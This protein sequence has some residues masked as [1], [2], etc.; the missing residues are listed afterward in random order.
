MTSEINRQRNTF[1]AATGG[2]LNPDRNLTL[3]IECLRGLRIAMNGC[4]ISSA[5]ADIGVELRFRA[6]PSTK[7]PPNPADV[8]GP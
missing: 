7:C 6:R 1:A 4:R 2:L 5:V 8:P 3:S